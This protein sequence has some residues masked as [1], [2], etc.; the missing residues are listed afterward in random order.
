MCIK[1]IAGL[2]GLIAMISTGY[3]I[4]LA[5]TEEMYREL[6]SCMRLLSVP[7]TW[8]YVDLMIVT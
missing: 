3:A 2:I 6:F 7:S 8:T 4:N 1:L 5:V